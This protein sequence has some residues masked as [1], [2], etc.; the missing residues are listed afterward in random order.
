MT[1]VSDMSDLSE[2]LG[3]RVTDILSHFEISYLEIAQKC[4]NGCLHCCL[5]QKANGP[6]MP[7]DRI[8]MIGEKGI[9][10]CESVSFTLGEPLLYF[11]KG[12]T[13]ADVIEIL[14]GERIKKFHII[15]GGINIQKHQHIKEALSKLK[16]LQKNNIPIFFNVTFH[17]FHRT[18]EIAVKKFINTINTLLDYSLN[19]IKI[20]MPWTPENKERTKELLDKIMEEHDWDFCVDDFIVSPIQRA[21]RILSPDYEERYKREIFTPWLKKCTWPSRKELMIR[22]DGR[23]LP[24]GFSE[25]YCANA[26]PIGNIFEDS[27]EELKQK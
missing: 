23:I 16:N 17:L 24:N 9:P 13:I 8:K 10:F 21:E 1:D 12:K 7:F 22:A 4:D 11:Y 15:T 3:E 19:G 20:K 26:E 18:E 6:E 27:T 2:I 5:D 25:P 14:L